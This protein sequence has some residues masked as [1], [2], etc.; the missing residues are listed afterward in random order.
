MENYGS[1]NW[2][3]RTPKKKNNGMHSNVWWNVFW[4]IF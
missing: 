4:I 3:R 2:N 1:L